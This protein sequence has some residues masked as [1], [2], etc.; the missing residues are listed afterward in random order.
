MHVVSAVMVK[1][2]P[3]ILALIAYGKIP[4]EHLPFAAPRTFAAKPLQ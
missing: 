3:A 1:F 2:L 4:A